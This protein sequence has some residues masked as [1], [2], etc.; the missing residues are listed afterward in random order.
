ML[1]MFIGSVLLTSIYLNECFR[2]LDANSHE[3]LHRMLVTYLRKCTQFLA[4][5]L[6]IFDGGTVCAFCTATLNEYAES[7]MKDQIYKVI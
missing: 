4:G 6:M 7:S 5:E 2:V 3:K 1:L